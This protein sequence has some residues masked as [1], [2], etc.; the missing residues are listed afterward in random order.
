MGLLNEER[1]AGRGRN[2][3]DDDL[4]YTRA[5]LTMLAAVKPTTTVMIQNLISRAI[6]TAEGDNS[7]E[8]RIWTGDTAMACLTA[9]SE[10]SI[11]FLPNRKRVHSLKRTP[12]TP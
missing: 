3:Y 12:D 4:L 11:R 8:C 1:C 6:D 2:L 7:M 5:L 10:R 9:T